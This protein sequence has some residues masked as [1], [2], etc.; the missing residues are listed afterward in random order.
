M[1]GDQYLF[2]VQTGVA[3]ATWRLIGLYGNVLFSSRFTTDQNAIVIPKSGSYTLIIEGEP[4][5]GSITADYAFNVV[6]QGNVSLQPFNGTSITIGENVTGSISVWGETDNFIFSRTDDSRLYFDSFTEE[7]NINWSLTG[8]AGTMVSERYFA[9]SDSWEVGNPVLNLV[10]GDY[11]LTINGRGSSTGDYQFRLLDFASAIEITPGTPVIGD[12]TPANESD[13]YQFSASAGEKFFFDVQTVDSSLWNTSWRLIDPVS[14]VIFQ[15]T[16]NNS[17]SVIDTQTLVRSGTYTLLIEGR[18][19]SSDSGTY[20]FN[21][22]PVV[23][24]A[25][26]AVAMGETVSASISVPG[27][28]DI[29]TFNIENDSR[30]YFDSLTNNY[31]MTWSLTGPSGAL[32]SDRSF[33]ASDS[34]DIANPVIKLVP[35]DYQ[36]SVNP[37]G[38]V[39]GAYQ[40]RLLD[41]ASAQAISPGTPVSGG[42]WPANESDLYQFNA[43]AGDK[44]FFDAQ[45]RSGATNASWRLIDPYNNK[46]FEAAFG[47]VSSDVDT[48]TMTVSGTYTLL[49]EGRYLDTGSATYT[50]NV[51]PIVYAAPV[52]FATGETVSGA[53]AVQGE[54]DTYTFSLTNNYRLY[55]DSLTNNSG[56]RWS[57]TG[58]AGTLVSNRTFTT[59]DSID[60]ANPVLKLVAGDYQLTV[61]GTGDV[62]GAYQFRLLDFASAL[63]I[64]PGSPVSG[65]MTP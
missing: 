11:L 17:F 22:A 39:T 58:P 53:I 12:L 31:Y 50:F 30:I 4:F 14:N 15:D 54:Q 38:D 40:F 20:T 41:F 35:G 36:L 5:A 13:I 64:T 24:A 51:A 32:V 34:A 1:A 29:Y 56:I 55:F 37:A 2:D 42:L 49:I 21:V 46:V 59:S 6:L 57:L 27:E 25:P 9:H 7:Y 65:D 10:A 26:V 52:S 33:R 28:Q 60:I 48:L 47:S 8:P 44:F 3:N 45:A 19:Y 61:D 43:V 63:A 62:I 23:D 18:V 16:F